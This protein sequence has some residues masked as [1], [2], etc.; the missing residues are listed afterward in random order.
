MPDLAVEINLPLQYCRFIR[1][2]F[3]IHVHAKPGKKYALN[4]Q[5]ALLSQLR[6]LTRVYGIS[7]IILVQGVMATCFKNW[8]P[9]GTPQTPQHSS[10]FVLV[11]CPDY[12]SHVEGKNSLGTKI[13]PE[14]SFHASSAP[15]ERVISQAGKKHVASW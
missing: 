8:R 11:S 2:A 5:Y 3:I 13:W 4:K 10:D 12:F 14:T 7:S 15:V 1:I 6:I 9:I